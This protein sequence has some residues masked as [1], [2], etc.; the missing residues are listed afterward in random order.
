MSAKLLI[1]QI[2]APR[3]Y[4]K[5]HTH[6]TYASDDPPVYIIKFLI[7]QVQNQCFSLEMPVMINVEF[8]HFLELPTKTSVLKNTS[9]SKKLYKC[10]FSYREKQQYTVIF[11]RNFSTKN[12]NPQNIRSNLPFQ[13]LF[14][15]KSAK[16][17][18]QFTN[19]QSFESIQKK[20]TKVQLP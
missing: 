5:P 8:K 9:K 16:H 4:C 17:L 2:F 1:Q 7:I 3:K 12:Q 13:E 20:H 15:S 11:V 10:D 6:D 19:L 14:T 18:Q